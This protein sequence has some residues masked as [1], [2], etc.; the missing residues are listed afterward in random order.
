MWR[1]TVFVSGTN[2]VQVAVLGGLTATADFTVTCSP[3]PVV[4]PGTTS[5][6]TGT[7]RCTC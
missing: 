1:I 7:V 2:P 3:V 4:P 6:S 5:R